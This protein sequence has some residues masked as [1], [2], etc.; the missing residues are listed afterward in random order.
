M[1]KFGA[2]LI[3]AAA[4]LVLGSCS[5]IGKKDFTAYLIKDFTV[6]I[7]EISGELE[8]DLCD[9]FSSLDDAEVESVKETI[10]AYSI[11]E[12]SFRIWDYA[13][14]EE[15][16]F[17]G[18]M[19]L[20]RV[21]DNLIQVSHDISGTSVKDLQ[22]AGKQELTLSAVQIETIKTSLLNDH[23]IKVF[24]HGDVDEAPMSFTVQILVRVNA[25]AEVEE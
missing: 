4:C 21:S 18:S 25:T 16:A 12:I 15:A 3:L 23:G 11:E 19:D 14:P 17:T 13:G 2:T 10:E 5:K 8:V 6:Q 7:D 1:T 9:I 22:D 24:F 20:G